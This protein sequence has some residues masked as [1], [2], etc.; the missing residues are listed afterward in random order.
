MCTMHQKR[1][2]RDLFG[3]FAWVAVSIKTV[4]WVYFNM[5][6]DCA[7]ATFIVEI[8]ECWQKLLSIE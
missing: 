4:E 6:A 7:S 8:N 1:S 3:G 2:T 5:P